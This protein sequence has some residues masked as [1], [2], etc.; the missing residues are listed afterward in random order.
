[1]PA[2]SPAER[3]RSDTHQRLIESAFA[4]LRDVP[5]TPLTH[6]TVAAHSGVSART[7]YRHFPTQDDLVAALWRHLRDRTGTRW[8]TTEAEIVPFLRELYAQFEQNDALTRAAI[9][10]L[11]RVNYAAHGAAEGREAFRQ[12]LADRCRKRT[13]S[14]ADQLIATCVAIYSAPFWQLLRDRGQLSARAA[15][16]AAVAAM[17]AVLD[18][19]PSS[20]AK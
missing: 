4:L 16:R 18:A 7:A 6:E 17:R 19:P 14:E 12:A 13:A 9:A 11:P 10:A 8:P 20:P 1:M 15:A 5:D 3:L 2:T